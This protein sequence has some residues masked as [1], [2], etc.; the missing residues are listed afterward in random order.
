[1]KHSLK[2][3]GL[4]AA[5]VLAAS[6]SSLSLAAAQAPA[7][8]PSAEDF[9]RTAALRNVSISP[10][11]K[12][13]AGVVSSDGKSSYISVWET[14]NLSKAPLN[15]GCGQRLD[16]VAVRFVKNDRLGITTRQLVVRGNDRDYQ[17]R[18]ILT[19]LDGGR[20]MTT[21]GDQDTSGGGASI[22]DFLP[23]DPKNIIIIDYTGGYKLNVYSGTKAKVYTSSDKFFG[24]M[25]DLNGEIRARMT[26]DYE[27]GRIYLAQYI[28]NAKTGAGEEHFRRFAA[29]REDQ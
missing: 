13:I 28:R 8:P 1:M 10:D 19:D 15:I 27:G 26:A 18:L 12:H 24:E 25:T 17:F 2:K 4:A 16:C 22:V 29:D 9:S 23:K 21:S 7:T 5:I 3:L 6:L 14:A 20:Q 11:G